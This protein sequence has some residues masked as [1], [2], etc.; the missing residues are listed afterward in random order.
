M[1]LLATG[2]VQITW[3][4]ITHAKQQVYFTLVFKASQR[5]KQQTLN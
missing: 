3:Q 5:R 1:R 2:A 4:D